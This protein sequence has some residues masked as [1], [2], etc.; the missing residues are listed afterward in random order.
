MNAPSAQRIDLRTALSVL[1]LAFVFDR[2]FWRQD[3]GLDLALFT[4]VAMGGAL[5]LRRSASVPARW[6]LGG[7]MICA[8]MVVVNGSVIAVVGTVAC[9]AVGAVLLLE[10]A[11]RNLP[12]ALVAAMFNALFA[13]IGVAGALNTGLT[14]LPAT[15][16]GWRW[17]RLA[18]IP[19]AVLLV[20]IF[21]Y[22]AAN[23]RFEALTAGFMDGL[24]DLLGDLLGEL[25]TPHVLFI[26]FALLVSVAL[27]HRSA[28]HLF[29]GAAW[30]LNETLTRIRRRRPH[31]LAPLAMGALDRERRM[32]VM[33]LVLVNALLLVVN[34]IDIAWV[35][36]GFTVEEGFDLKQFVHEGTWL[37]I[38][39]ILLSMAI[40]LHLFRGNLNF[41]PKQSTLRM[42]ATAWIA[43][44]FILGVSV[45]LRNYHYIHF[46]GL[47]YKRIGVIVF[48]ALMLV[49]LVTLY[50][51]VRG[52]RTLVY[53]LRVNGWA[54]FVALVG[55]S[56]VNWDGVIVRFNLAH[57]N[58]GEI[59]VDNYLAMSDKVLPLLYADLPKVEAQMAKHRG[60]RVRWVE[61]LD[62]QGFRADLDRKRER[63]IRRYLKQDWRSW[64]LADQRTFEA[65]EARHL[66]TA[67]PRE[68]RARRAP[69]DAASEAVAARTAET[70]AT[71]ADEGA[72]N[73]VVEAEAH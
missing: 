63:F 16:T 25:V 71:M 62:P 28:P 51:K 24:I 57:W 9:L 15:R 7:L 3:I 41:H 37:L 29:A 31:W 4:V 73:A 45:F 61:H 66:A 11:Q 14:R 42:L 70:L 39:S 10:P 53:L 5:A 64:T 12:V 50:L 8:T 44:N 55:L 26:G 6:V 47:A 21:I 1:G 67:V 54:A 43:Q 2:L 72:S 48:L 36:A 13:P 27:L 56:T 22:R 59:D 30:P 33:L 32:G 17:T 34:L 23:P 35:W 46:H 40:L 65:L 60:N 19:L 38:L 58:Q 52:Q 68:E 18:L 49:G 20:Y 69:A